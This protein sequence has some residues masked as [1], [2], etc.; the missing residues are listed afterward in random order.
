MKD[1]ELGTLDRFC[2]GYELASSY[3]KI[4][5]SHRHEKYRRSSLI[6]SCF[7]RAGSSHSTPSHRPWVPSTWPTNLMVPRW[8]ARASRAP[9]A[10]AADE[11]VDCC[12]TLPVVL[13]T[14]VRPV[15]VMSVGLGPSAGQAASNAEDLPKMALATNRARLW[16]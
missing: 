6:P 1:P 14:C 12:I 16:T 11:L 2:R 9:T 7:P 5:R 10:G 13:T 3:E 15:C 4:E 8:P